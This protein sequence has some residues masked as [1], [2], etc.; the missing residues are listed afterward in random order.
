L[1]VYL[2]YPIA[3]M[4]GIKLTFFAI[5]S[6]KLYMYRNST[7]MATKDDQH[8]QLYAFVFVKSW[9]S[10]SKNLTEIVL[11]FFTAS[12]YSANCSL[13]WGFFTYLK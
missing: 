8:Q 12:D 10:C 13:S 6:V 9:K 11:W 3:V 5:T 1:G 4:M 7:K 2:Y